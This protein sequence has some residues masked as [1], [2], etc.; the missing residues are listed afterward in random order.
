MTTLETHRLISRP[1]QQADVEP[2]FALSNDPEVMRFFGGPQTRET[3]EAVVETAMERQRDFGVWFQPL[4]LKE[5][6]A[7]IG[8]AGI[9]KVLF[10]APFTPAVEIGWGFAPETWGQGY[11]SEAGRAALRHGFEQLGDPRIID[12]VID[13]HKA[14]L[15]EMCQSLRGG[16][17]GSML[18]VEVGK[19]RGTIHIH[20]RSWIAHPIPAFASSRGCE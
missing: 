14:V 11:A 1:W 10:E 13:N 15:V 16:A 8:I 3:V 7:F 18:G 6:G 17:E 4:I 2:F 5:T 12:K 19:R 20:R 9:A